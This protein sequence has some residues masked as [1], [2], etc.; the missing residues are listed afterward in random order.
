MMTIDLIIDSKPFKM[1]D[2]K[3]KPASVLERHIAWLK[4]DH[5]RCNCLVKILAVVEMIFVTLLC[6]PLA[7]KCFRIS[8]RMNAEKKFKEVVSKITTPDQNIQIEFHSLTRTF[9][10]TH[11]IIIENGFLWS[12]PRFSNR[13]WKP[14][15][16]DGF[17]QNKRPISLHADG[18]N[19]IVL[20][21]DHNVHYRKL[22]REYRNSEI[23]EDKPKVM[24]KIEGTDVDLSKDE[25]VVIDLTEK[26]NWIQRWF[27]LPVI[28][29]FARFFLPAK[30]KLPND[31]RAFAISH[32]G[33]YNNYLED[34][35]GAH[36]PVEEGVTTLYVL[37]KNGKSIFKYD[38]WSPR[39]AKMN[40]HVPET[41]T[42]SF[43]ALNLSAA[44]SHLMLLGY[45]STKNPIGKGIINRLTI[46]TKLA[47]IDSEGWNP[48][49]KYSYFK[50]NAPNIRVIPKTGW[51]DHALDLKEG[52]KV[53]KN[54]MILQLGEGNDAREIC[55]E[56][57]DAS[58]QKGYFY[59]RVDA[60]EWQFKPYAKGSRNHDQNSALN[61]L[62]IKEDQ[63]F[64]SSVKDFKADKVTLRALKKIEGLSATLRNFGVGQT[65]SILELQIQKENYQL[66]LHRKK[67][68][69]NFVGIEG[70]NYDLV[71]PEQLQKNEKIYKLFNGEKVLPINIKIENGRLNLKN[72]YLNMT[73]S[74]IKS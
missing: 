34:G 17:I 68:F 30:L 49:L 50:E 67:T 42:T 71:V 2:D 37:E 27:T 14:M 7:I 3:P 38:P 61:I 33:R 18:A 66:M 69:K 24:R 22:I 5:Q 46:K 54:I 21:N 35:V 64:S 20:D 65:D 16:F 26:N 6:F 36:H 73:F 62:E 13:A 12:R 57:W 39:F 9:T 43:Q 44:G 56:G 51:R 45:E 29:V 28:S 32:R 58:G 55:I 47:D 48:G 23:S 53:S 10:H 1:I 41:S 15:Y 70:D 40:I 11:E 25:Y 19:L 52:Q 4:G 74:V 8:E 60:N 63:S 31:T 72:I 59:K